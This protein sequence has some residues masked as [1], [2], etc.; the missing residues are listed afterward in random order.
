[1]IGVGSIPK[2]TSF[3]GDKYILVKAKMQLLL[4]LYTHKV[5]LV[6]N[7]TS[8][9]TKVKNKKEKYCKNKVDKAQK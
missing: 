8:K 4:E 9:Q 6:P 1:V 7:S 2:G 3:L 5:G